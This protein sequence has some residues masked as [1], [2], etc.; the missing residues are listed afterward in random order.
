MTRRRFMFSAGTI[1]FFLSPELLGDKF[2]L[3]EAHS[4]DACDLTWPELK[5]LFMGV[6]N[7]EG[8]EVACAVAQLT[9]HPACGSVSPQPPAFHLSLKDVSCDELYIIRHGEVERVYGVNPQHV[10]IY[11]R[12]QE[13]SIIDTVAFDCPPGV[14]EAAVK[15]AIRNAMQEIHRTEDDDR[16][17][18]MDDVLTNAAQKLHATWAYLPIIECLEVA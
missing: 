13:S 18:Y 14:T 17:S 3:E 7:Q 1:G 12:E 5:A 16:L 6:Q 8:F 4:S 9:Y 15:Q 11:Y 10:Q 2:E